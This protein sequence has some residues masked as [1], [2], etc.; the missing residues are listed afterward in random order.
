M[1]TAQTT[2]FEVRCPS[3]NVS[4]P[5][6]TKRCV[7]CGARTSSDVESA[8]QSLRS[9]I[10]AAQ[11]SEEPQ[12]WVPAEHAEHAGDESPFDEVDDESHVPRPSLLRRSLTLIWV[13]VLVG[14]SLIRACMEQ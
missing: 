6:G 13:L 1:K 7:H 8:A 10:A 5:V 11:Q 9:R 12:P 14:F 4:F 3:C 2:R